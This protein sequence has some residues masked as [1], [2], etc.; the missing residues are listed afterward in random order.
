MPPP[1]KRFLRRLSSWIISCVLF[2]FFF[3][4]LACCGWRSE[5]NVS[6]V[7]LGKS[8]VSRMSSYISLVYELAGA[9]RRP[10]NRECI[11]EQQ[12]QWVSLS[13]SKRVRESIAS[14]VFCIMRDKHEGPGP[15]D[16]V[17]CVRSRRPIKI[18]DR[19]GQVLCVCVCNVW[20]SQAI[21][22]PPLT[23]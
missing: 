8:R 16:F 22:V 10:D 21:Y 1:I 17:P 12:K 4:W 9:R 2:L 3:Y 15:H 18:S 7:C 5:K 19:R 6:I 20:N 11:I 13:Q 14:R 23:L